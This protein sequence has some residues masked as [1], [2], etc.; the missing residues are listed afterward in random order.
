MTEA[1]KRAKRKYKSKC[2]ELRITLYPTD[3][4]II[5]KVDSLPEYSPYIKG[6]IRKDI[7][8]KKG[9]DEICG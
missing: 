1:Q 7:N 6:L 3:K 5:D 2:R 4:D 8:N 9:G